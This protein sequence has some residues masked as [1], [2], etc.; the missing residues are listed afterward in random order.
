MRPVESDSQL[1][2]RLRNSD[3]RL[4]VTS[5]ANEHVKAKLGG[6][7]FEIADPYWDLRSYQEILIDEIYKFEAETDSPLILDC[8]ANI[9]FS[10]VYFK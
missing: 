4:L 2:P 8:G 9:G 5:A 7:P 1:M 10:V 6:C 3:I